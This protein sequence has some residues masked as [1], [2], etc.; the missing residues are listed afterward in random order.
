MFAFKSFR[1]YMLFLKGKPQNFP[2]GKLNVSIS[3]RSYRAHMM[4]GKICWV[5]SGIISKFYDW[6]SRNNELVVSW[7]PFE[8]QELKLQEAVPG[9]FA[10]GWPLLSAN[11]AGQLA[12]RASGLR[13]K[14][15]QWS[16]SAGKERAIF[17]HGRGAANGN[18][19]IALPFEASLRGLLQVQVTRGTALGKSILYLIS[20]PTSASCSCTTP[21]IQRKGGKCQRMGREQRGWPVRPDRSWQPLPLCSP[22]WAP[23]KPVGKPCSVPAW[24]LFGK[25]GEISAAMP[26]RQSLCV[27]GAV[28]RLQCGAVSAWANDIAK[29]FWKSTCKVGMVKPPKITRKKITFFWL[30]LWDKVPS[31]SKLIWLYCFIGTVMA[32]LVRWTHPNVDSVQDWS[33]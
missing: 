7:L 3:L 22:P 27:A 32:Y 20:F 8:P 6:C 29:E 11:P 5:Y 25:A 1:W 17:P 15:F 9:L 2:L 16:F 24:L 31:G 12:C 14:V 26:A 30:S 33:H 23:A 13:A 10:L 18:T 21:A 19:Q 4:K 28:K